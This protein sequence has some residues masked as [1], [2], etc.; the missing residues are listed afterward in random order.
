MKDWESAW[1]PMPN[2]V[3]L[4]FD[5]MVLEENAEMC[6]AEWWIWTAHCDEN[7]DDQVCSDAVEAWFGQETEWLE[8]TR[9]DEECW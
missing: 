9:P 1:D 4:A 3:C 8:V 5:T 2:E 6:D 7:E